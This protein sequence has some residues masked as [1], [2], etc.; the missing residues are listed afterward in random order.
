VKR[1]PA[2]D[3]AASYWAAHFGVPCH[4]LFTEPL[5]I[6]SHAGELEEYH[7][8]FALSRNGARL[9]SLPSEY[10]ESLRPIVLNLS[11]NFSLEDLARALRPIASAVI[12]PAFIGYTDDI[13]QPSHP[14]R[15]LTLEDATA[16]DS[17]RAACGETEWE[18]GGSNIS[19]NPASGVFI[20]DKLAAL[21]AYEVWGGTIAHI[22]VI[23]HPEHRGRGFGTAAVTHLSARA[24][25]AGL[26]PQY[27]TL[28]GNQPSIRLAKS[29]G[30]VRYA[31]SLAIRLHSASIHA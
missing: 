20:G 18:R 26:L 11:S 9:I 13:S 29:I 2:I 4:L 15:A 12:G 25:A 28:D 24:L 3:I 27:R 22:S 7:G 6:I 31:T 14:A 21:A 10:A 30:F 8:I 1:K 16:V 23:T 17:L 5:S 19:V